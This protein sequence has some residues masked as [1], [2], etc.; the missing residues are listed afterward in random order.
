MLKELLHSSRRVMRVVLSSLAGALVVV[1]VV[2]VISLNNRPDLKVWHTTVLD[3]EFSV[4]SGL[5]NF[6]QYL[7]LEERLFKQLDQL[8]YQVIDKTDQRSINRYFKDSLSDPGRWPTNWNRSFVLPV[9]TPAIGVLL[10]HGMSDSPYS[11][12]SIGQLLHDHGAYVI[13]MRVPGHGQAPSGLLDVEWEDMAAAV[14][15]AVNE[16]QDKS[17]GVPLYIVGYS[18][19]GAL[20]VQYTL[21]SLT[22]E[23]LKTVDGLVLISPEIG[24]SKIAVLAKSQERLGHLLGLEKLA[25]NSLLPEYDPW[26]YGS[27]ALN[28]AIQAYR[29]TQEIQRQI[30]M[31]A[32]AGVLDHVPLPSPA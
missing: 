30:T 1:V 12:H 27:F 19:G 26:K 15:L 25:W 2:V 21:D 16:L 13:G 14:R 10:L 32:K 24:I 5:K 28:A 11:L 7:E 17:P 18:N 6:A 23:R 29:I 4:D 3:Q 31:Q 22:D 9:E 20:A 8:I